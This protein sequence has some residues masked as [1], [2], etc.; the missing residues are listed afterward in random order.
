MERKFFNLDS[1]SKIFLIAP[2]GIVTGGVELVHQLADVL[3]RNGKNAYILYVG[4]KPHEVPE[5][6]KKYELCITDEIEDTS[7]NVVVL[8]E[9]FIRRA[10][11]YKNAQILIWWMSVDNYFLSFQGNIFQTFRYSKNIN[12][13]LALKNTIK[14]IF[15]KQNSTFSL[16]KIRDTGNIVC[17]AYQS[18][19]AADFL[20]NH[21]IGN[22]FPLKDYINV[23]YVYQA[24]NKNKE[25][26]VLYNPKK[27][28]KFTDRLIKSAPDLNWTPIQNMTRTQVKK[29]M[30]KSKVY[31]DFGYHPGKDRLPR[32]AAMCGCC[33]ITGKLGAAGFYGDLSIRD[34]FKFNQTSKDIKTIITKVRYLLEHYDE[35][36]N[37]YS[38]Y[39]ELIAKEKKEFEDNAIELFS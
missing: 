13:K 15:Y 30:Q 19:Y 12:F 17:N 29:L 28:K 1:N 36:I 38:S 7:N 35:K 22:I 31:I 21:K 8:P 3:N 2:A 26:I 34:E 6:Y 14:K 37:D 23:D 33:I 16:K 32:E 9:V 27:G 24:P 11:L 20:R 4:D 39:R 25:N 10:S 18:E 5:D